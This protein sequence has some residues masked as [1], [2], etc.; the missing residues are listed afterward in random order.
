VSNKK[1]V[2]VFSVHDWGD[3]ACLWRRVVVPALQ[4]PWAGEQVRQPN[5]KADFI[6]QSGIKNWLLHQIH[7]MDFED[8]S[9]MHNWYQKHSHTYITHLFSVVRESLKR[10]ALKIKNT[11]VKGYRATTL[12]GILPSQAGGEGPS[13]VL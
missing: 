3:E 1:S 11:E 9:K 7:N 2:A 10:R 5:A 4:A 13:F 8:S 12:I 6:P